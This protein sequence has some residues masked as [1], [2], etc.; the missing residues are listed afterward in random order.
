M[1]VSKQTRVDP[2]LVCYPKSKNALTQST[3]TTA[4][5][6]LMRQLHKGNRKIVS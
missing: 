5:V 6:Q 2:Q 3:S 4:T 1:V